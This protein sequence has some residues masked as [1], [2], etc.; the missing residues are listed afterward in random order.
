MAYEFDYHIAKRNSVIREKREK[1]NFEQ[2]KKHRKDIYSIT[3]WLFQN[4]HKSFKDHHPP[5]LSC[6]V[7]DTLLS[8]FDKYIIECISAIE[9]I[10]AKPSE[11]SYS[12]D[13]LI[14]KQPKSSTMERYIERKN[15][16]IDQTYQK[17]PSNTILTNKQDE[18]ETT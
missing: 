9:Y 18:D 8:A 4:R 13:K 2:Y 15:I 7:S 6:R 17:F 11:H 5:E 14:E 10:P 16:H 12:I 1:L 3:K